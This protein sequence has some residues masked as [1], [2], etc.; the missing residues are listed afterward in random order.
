MKTA[1][2]VSAVLLLLASVSSARMSDRPARPVV[3]HPHFHSSHSARVK[4][5]KK[6]QA[7][8]ARSLGIEARATRITRGKV[9]PVENRVSARKVTHGEAKNAAQ[10]H[11][12]TKAQSVAKISARG[13]FVD[14]WHPPLVADAIAPLGESVKITRSSA[15]Q[16]S[17][18][19]IAHARNLSGASDG[20]RNHSIEALRTTRNIEAILRDALSGPSRFLAMDVI[21]TLK[22]KNL[23]PDLVKLSENDPT[24]TYYLTLNSLI[25]SFNE[26]EYKELYAKR[27]LSGSAQPAARMILLDTLLRMQFRLSPKQLSEFLFHDP[28]PEVRES[29]LY[30]LHATLLAPRYDDFVPLLREVLEEKKSS[31]QR[32]IQALFTVSE[33]SPEL[34]QGVQSVV[35][36]CPQPEPE[37]LKAVCSRFARSGGVK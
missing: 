6:A 32:R 13:L 25:T 3:K 10:V 31:R 28:S 2:K 12:S 27:L 19:W 7:L 4:Q 20:V 36:P 14:V 18:A 22:L 21:S 23:I 9:R 16:V 11:G 33:L 24:G 34:F 17:K 15:E 35:S 26:K 5:K 1:T 30:Y 8:G 37:D 29:A